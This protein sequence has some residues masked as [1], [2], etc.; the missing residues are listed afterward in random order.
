MTT[1]GRGLML[2]KGWSLVLLVLFACGA[3]RPTMPNSKEIK[4]A[5]EIR[6]LAGRVTAVSLPDEIAETLPVPK[7][8]SGTNAIQILYYREVGVPDK[9]RVTPPEHCLLL[10]AESGALLRFWACR[11]EELGITPRAAAVPGAG[12]SDQM[13]I[14]EYIDKE[15]RLL[16]I[17]R[18]VWQAFFAGG[19]PD[20]PATRELAR[21]Y[22]QLFL[23]TT[24]AEV[25]PFVV[26]A[27]ADFFQWLDIAAQ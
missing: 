19:V 21:E 6:E 24:K 1:P 3:Q 2:W 22:R 20:D 7:R 9:R 14:D 13:S 18:P 26:A 23:E 10:D 25:A 15:D 11:P 17:S 4:T 16:D 8:V 27:A 5:Q 12:V